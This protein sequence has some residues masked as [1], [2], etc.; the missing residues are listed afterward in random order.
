MDKYSERNNACAPV[1][2]VGSECY[3]ECCPVRRRRF[4]PF[5]IR[6]ILSF[7]EFRFKQVS[8]LWVN[9]CNRLQL[10]SSLLFVNSP[11]SQVPAREP[12]KFFSP[13]L[14]SQLCVQCICDNISLHI[15]TPSPLFTSFL[16]HVELLVVRN[17]RNAPFTMGFSQGF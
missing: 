14:A 9:T 15:I 8:R 16:C 6:I 1:T 2:F 17:K 13:Q 10:M 3:D 7:Q 4:V 11:A 12:N 5:R